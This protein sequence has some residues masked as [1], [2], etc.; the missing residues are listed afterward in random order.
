[1]NTCGFVSPKK[2]LQGGHASLSDMLIWTEEEQNRKKRK[3]KK[4]KAMESQRAREKEREQ[5]TAAS[6]ISHYIEY[7]V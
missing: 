7:S 6:S 2:Y 3:D 4:E 1:M 5:T